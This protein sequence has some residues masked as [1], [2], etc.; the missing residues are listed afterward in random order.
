MNAR[1]AAISEAICVLDTLIADEPSDPYDESF[2]L[3]A[4]LTP[5]RDLLNEMLEEPKMTQPQPQPEFVACACCGLPAS[6]RARFE[7]APTPLLDV[8]VPA[9]DEPRAT[10][11]DRTVVREVESVIDRASEADVRPL[12]IL[13]SLAAALDA[14]R[15]RIIVEAQEVIDAARVLGSDA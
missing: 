13:A 5:V 10:D 9:D 6:W 4:A 1:R 12:L 2:D 8:P 3:G 14:Y 7:E 11:V 15:A